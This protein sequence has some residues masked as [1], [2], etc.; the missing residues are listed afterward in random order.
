MAIL[1]SS[2]YCR[3]HTYCLN[4]ICSICLKNKE[5][6]M[7]QK[8][9]K[10]HISSLFMI[11]SATVMCAVILV[12]QDLFKELFSYGAYYLVFALFLV[13]LFALFQ[14]VQQHN[15]NFQN[16]IW[17]HKNG[18]IVSVLI[19][20]IIFTSVKPMFR[21]LSDETN[22][23]AVSKSMVYEKR[24]DNVTMGKWYYDNF[25]PLNR[26]IEKRPLMFPFF[27]N[28]IH[29]FI[30]YRPENVFILNFF[31]L[32]AL[33]YMIYLA[34][35]D[36]SSEMWAIVAVIFVASQPIVSQC[37]TSGG[38]DLFAT[39]FLLM[40]LLILYT[41]LNQ[42]S[43]ATFQLLWVS[44][45][46]LTNTR[47]EG[48]LPF[49]IIMGFLAALNYVKSEYFKGGS[50]IIYSLTP[51]LILPVVWQRFL[52]QKS[53][54][55]PPDVPAFSWGHFINNNLSF[56]K[57]LVDFRFYLPYATLVNILGLAG[58]L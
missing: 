56:L 49:L 57:S 25:Y 36:I 29:T 4:I 40:C 38:F 39:V 35:K 37:A 17:A 7:V 52:V 11:A 5:P 32:L 18:I 51:L 33:L 45:L 27:L 2:R 16:T 34:V 15:S 14:Y 46:M 1:T 47:Y 12:R 54:E 58:L 30:G 20:S 48:I 31:V 21:V 44:L 9:I 42:P 19:T 22:L 43:A 8:N 26:E 6:A 3:K 50:A 13:W 53:V 23:V 55:N 10:Y 24:T 28:I 41:F